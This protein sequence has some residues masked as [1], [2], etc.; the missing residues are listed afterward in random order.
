MRL[1]STI[2]LAALVPVLWSCS[3]D[4]VSDVDDYARINNALS[5]YMMAIDVLANASE[6]DRVDQALEILREHVA[7]DFTVSIPATGTNCPS[8]N[9]PAQADGATTFLQYLDGAF[10]GL[11]VT[12]AVHELAVP[13][14]QIDGSSATAVSA[15]SATHVISEGRLY[16]WRGAYRDELIKRNERWM[17]QSRIIDSA[18]DRIMAA[19]TDPTETARMPAYIIGFVKV[20]DVGPVS[21]YLRQVPGFH[22]KWGGKLLSVSRSPETMEGPGTD[23]EAVVLLEFPDYESAR[24]YYEDPGYAAAREIR[25]DAAQVNA[26][27][28]DGGGQL[29]GG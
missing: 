4:T 8:P 16:V 14:I 22:D 12:R 19:E 29:G 28:I 3:A 11:G 6:E 21:E 23:A 10:R 9:C 2:F 24:G 15:F 25:R 20:S 18:F 27:L 5:G 26:I 13:H 17:I 7:G 1:K